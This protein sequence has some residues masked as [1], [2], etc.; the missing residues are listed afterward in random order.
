MPRLEPGP[1]HFHVAEEPAYTC[2]GAG[3]HLYVE[4]EKEGL[5]TDQLAE[6]LARAC[7]RTPRDVGYA[8]RKDRWGITRQWFSIHFGDEAGLAKL[9]EL[10]RHGRATVVATGRHGNKL[11]LGHLLGN[12]FRLGLTGVDDHD[13]LA[14]KLAALARDGIR[15][16]FGTQR[17]GHA[18]ATLAMARAWGARDWQ[19]AAEI[20][21]DPD[22]AWRWGQPLPD[23]FRGGPEGRAL[24]A[25]RR[26]ADARAALVA[27]GDQLRKLAA[28]AA[29]SAVFNAVLAA[30][31]EA[32]LLHRLR[33]GDLGMTPRGA[34]FLVEPDAAADATARAAPGRLEAFT[35]GPLPGT[36]RLRPA[37]DVDAEERAWAAGT[38]VDWAWMADDGALESPGERRPLLIP[39]RAA[40]TLER[41]G[42]VTWLAF[43]LP[44]GAYATE[45]LAQVGVEVP[46]DR[47]GDG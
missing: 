11:R 4:I 28:S 31:A 8:G 14:A 27:T 40:P 3:E 38:G 21:V 35:T 2:S 42:D 30:R 34:P 32:G 33:P 43:S 36:S 44:S 17:F 19:R 23:G 39:F 20:I 45:V 6:S 18:G 1:R 24:G 22:G 12:R 9:P 29:Q 26:G 37:S 15:N 16:A 25:L 46:Q 10:L 41:E 7:G 47:R 5:T 13:A